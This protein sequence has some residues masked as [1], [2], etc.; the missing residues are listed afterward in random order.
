LSLR[1]LLLGPRT[2]NNGLPKQDVTSSF[3]TN[4]GD[5]LDFAYNYAKDGWWYSQTEAVVK[6]D[7]KAIAAF[8]ETSTWQFQACR[9]AETTTRTITLPTLTT[10]TP[11]IT[12]TITATLLPPYIFDFGYDD[13]TSGWYENGIQIM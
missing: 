5:N 10:I 2:S 12:P 13:M 11:T 6:Q 4:L 3:P 1:C 9:V 7:M 8:T